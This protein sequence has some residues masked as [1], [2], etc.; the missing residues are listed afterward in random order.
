MQQTCFLLDPF[1]ANGVGHSVSMPSDK[2]HRSLMKAALLSLLLPGLG[3]LYIG[4]RTEGLISLATAGGIICAILLSA[5]GPAALRSHVSVL[6]LELAYLSVWVASIVEAS[7]Q[8]PKSR[9]SLL[10]GERAWFLVLMLAMAGPLALP[11]LW[12]SKQFSRRRKIAWTLVVI[13]A[14][15]VGI[16]SVILLGP[17]LEA[18]SSEILHPQSY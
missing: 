14:L 11:M 18:W 8:T 12:H 2:S 16:L 7:D 13:S 10:A 1:G 15:V 3:Q 17:Q 6:F 5:V 9:Q 4:R